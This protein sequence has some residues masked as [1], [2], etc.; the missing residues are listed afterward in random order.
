VVLAGLAGG[1]CLGAG[2]GAL[3]AGCMPLAFAAR[4]RRAFSSHS[5]QMSCFG[6]VDLKLLPH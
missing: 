6:L 5:G 3:V 1:I 2:V 4:A